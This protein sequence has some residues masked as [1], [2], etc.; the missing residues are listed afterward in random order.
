MNKTYYLHTYDFN[1]DSIV[2]QNHLLIYEPQS[3]FSL[4]LFMAQ[5]VT[6]FYTGVG[7]VC[8]EYDNETLDYTIKF[9]IA[10]SSI[11]YMKK[12]FNK[13]SRSIG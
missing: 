2:L 5:K 3:L 7:V 12:I 9:D 8:Y 1:G 11:E 6:K 4:C 13:T 10:P